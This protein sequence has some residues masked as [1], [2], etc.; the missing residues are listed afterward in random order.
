MIRSIQKNRLAGASSRAIGMTFLEL[1]VVISIISVISLIAIPSMRGPHEKN[2]LR[3]AARE[4]VATMRYARSAAIMFDG[5]VKMEVDVSE[6]RYR[7]VLPEM[8]KKKSKWAAG[9]ND[10]PQREVEYWR[11]LPKDKRG[12][13]EIEN[14]YSWDS[15]KPEKGIVR[16]LFFAD[17]SA[18]DASITLLNKFDQR[19]TIYLNRANGVTRVEAGGVSDES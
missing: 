5:K 7:L 15:P 10:D 13:I 1:L 18:S 2:K 4:I 17:G 9:I 14:I 6:Q 3:A 11:D 19:M 8:A 12:R 16:I